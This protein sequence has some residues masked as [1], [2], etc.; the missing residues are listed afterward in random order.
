[1]S[2][3]GRQRTGC[4]DRGDGAPPRGEMGRWRRRQEVP[5][6][7]REDWASHVWAARR[8]GRLRGRQGEARPLG[9][10]GGS[11]QQMQRRRHGESMMAA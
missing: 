5:L 3:A 1:M 4:M 11:R 10:R 8:T 2:L 7:H 9:A 6:T